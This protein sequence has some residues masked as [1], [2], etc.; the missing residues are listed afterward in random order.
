[1][2]KNEEVEELKIKY[3][4][5]PKCGN[6]MSFKE[7]GV[8]LDMSPPIY[9]YHCRNCGQQKGLMDFDEDYVQ[10]RLA[11][12]WRQHIIDDENDCQKE[13]IDKSLVPS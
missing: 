9:P 4:S 8:I 13:R 6:R 2:R 3:Y 10:Q 12:E 5:C 7:D 11:R 1:M